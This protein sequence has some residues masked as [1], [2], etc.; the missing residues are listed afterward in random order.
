MHRTQVYLEETHCQLLRARAKRE[1][2]SLAAV[3]REILDQ[4][5][6]AADGGSVDDPFAR[7]IGIGKGDGSTVAE[8]YEDY[9]YGDKI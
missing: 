9:L 5:F 1:G 8:N 7:V 3:L 2:K 4:H 6:S